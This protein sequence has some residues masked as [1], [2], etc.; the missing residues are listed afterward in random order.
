MAKQDDEPELIPVSISLPIEIVER[1]VSEAQENGQAR[2]TERLTLA[3]H[4]ISGRRRREKFLPGIR[5]GEASWD[6]ILD[7]YVATI[8]SRKVDASGLCLASG[9]APTT[10]VRYVEMLVEDGYVGRE[11]DELDGRRSFVTMKP[12]LRAA[13]ENW[14]DAEIAALKLT[15]MLV[16]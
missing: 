14:L 4:V 11:P 13:I 6:M 5:F 10:A 7:L 15:S 9:V 3:K 16:R 2:E 1:L 12:A 8:E